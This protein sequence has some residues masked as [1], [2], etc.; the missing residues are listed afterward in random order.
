MAQLDDGNDLDQ[1]RRG[2]CSEPAPAQAGS[3]GW[4]IAASK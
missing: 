1:G 3:F 2:V 4:G